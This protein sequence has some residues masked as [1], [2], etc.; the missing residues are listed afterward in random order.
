[1][2]ERGKGGGGISLTLPHGRRNV[3]RLPRHLEAH[4]RVLLGVRARQRIQAVLFDEAP[5][6]EQVDVNLK[7]DH[8]STWQCCLYCRLLVA[9]VVV[10]IG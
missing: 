4:V 2:K 10:V 5:R 1:M 8:A 7:P 6:A 9:V 3:I